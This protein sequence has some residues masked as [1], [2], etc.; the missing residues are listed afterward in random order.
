MIEICAIYNYTYGRVH[1]VPDK[2]CIVLVSLM[3]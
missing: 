3:K 2:S 1:T